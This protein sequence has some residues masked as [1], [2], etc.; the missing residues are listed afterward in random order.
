[1]DISKLYDEG[2]RREAICKQKRSAWNGFK[3]D[4]RFRKCI[5]MAETLFLS[6]STSLSFG[7]LWRATSIFVMI[8]LASLTCSPMRYIW[9]TQSRGNPAH[10]RDLYGLAWRKYNKVSLAA[11]SIM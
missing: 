11:I 8:C 3:G 2:T 5:I 1:M 6:T 4:S 7:V 10:L 9:C